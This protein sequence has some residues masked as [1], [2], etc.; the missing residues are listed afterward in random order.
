[1]GATFEQRY[2]Y[3]FPTA[4]RFGKGV[5]D[6]IAPHLIALGLKRPLFVTDKGL[7]K[8]DVFQQIFQQVKA[9]GLTA[10]VFSDINI[11]P[12]KANVLAGVE[13]FKA[14][15]CDAIIGMGGG[16][17]MDVARAIAL[18][19]NHDC[20]LFD[21]DEAVDGWQK[22]T[23]P[24]PY[25]ITIPTTS[26]T[27]SEVG[28]S[29]IIAEDKSHKKRILFSPKILAAQVFADPLLTL[30]LPVS[31]TAATGIDALT[32]NIEA[33]LAKGFHPLCDG[34]ALQAI[35]LISQ[36]LETAV[37]APDLASRSKMMIAS[38]MGA[39]AF[40]KGLGV[41]HSCAHAMSTLCNTHHGLANAIILPYGIKFNADVAEERLMII[42]K[43][44]QLADANVESLVEY[45]LQLNKSIYLPNR[46]SEINITHA[47]ISKL[48]ALAFQD[49]CHLSNP[50]KV[51]LKDFQ[52]IFTDA[53]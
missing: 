22:V 9:Q 42:A 18:Q 29:A 1:M 39:T 52:Q 49:V 31:I 38:L 50:K 45:L 44:L 16:A 26:G 35:Q 2:S 27:G 23:Q 33:Y 36:S 10:Q 14:S 17:S 43:V 4:I 32:H 34:I 28:R 47:D 6:E 24:I 21:F 3:H 12:V 19:V 46:L 13:C 5:S 40:Q 8:L 51:T 11:N 41:I 20:D 48:S 15:G 53:L 37:H 30:N 7:T 25:F